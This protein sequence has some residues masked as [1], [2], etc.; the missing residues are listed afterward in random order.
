MISFAV[1][2]V[3]M[4]GRWKKVRQ[5]SVIQPHFTLITKYRTENDSSG[6]ARKQEDSFLLSSLCLGVSQKL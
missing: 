2:V 6:Y 4:R 1:D 5:R 3:Y